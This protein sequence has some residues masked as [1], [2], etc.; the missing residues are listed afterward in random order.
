LKRGGRHV[1]GK[2]QEQTT[3]N[4]RRKK[5]FSFQAR[6]VGRGRSK[7]VGSEH[8][9][10]VGSGKGRDRTKIPRKKIRGRKENFPSDK[11]GGN[12]RCLTRSP[13]GQHTTKKIRREGSRKT[14]GKPKD[15]I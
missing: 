7:K 2:K 15:P 3:R 9:K 6:G 11:S 13:P 4:P 5:V 14:K 8:R 10:A 1:L 12:E